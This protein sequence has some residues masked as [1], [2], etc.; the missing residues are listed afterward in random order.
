MIELYRM[1]FLISVA[2]TLAPSP[3]KAELISSSLFP[4]KEKEK[5][6][7]ADLISAEYLVLG[8]VNE[9]SPKLFYCKF[10]SLYSQQGALDVTAPL[11]SNC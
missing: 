4:P 7:K 2:E 9:K 3:T 10:N 5:R 6:D 1:F 8:G 11:K